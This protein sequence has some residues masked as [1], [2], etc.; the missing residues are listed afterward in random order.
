MAPVLSLRPR[1]RR[2]QVEGSRARRGPPRESKEKA[3]ASRPQRQRRCSARRDPS[4][5]RREPCPRKELRPSNR[6]PVV[7]A[8]SALV[9]VRGEAT[10]RSVLVRQRAAVTARV[11]PASPARVSPVTSRRRA[12]L[13]TRRWARAEAEGRRGPHRPRHQSSVRRQAPA[14]AGAT[15]Q[16]VRRPSLPSPVPP[17]RPWSWLANVTAPQGSRSNRALVIPVPPTRATKAMAVMAVMATAAAAMPASC[18]AAPLAPPP[19]DS[20]SRRGSMLA[21]ARRRRSAGPTTSC[22]PASPP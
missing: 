3:S 17:S 5:S 18:R 12:R 10:R 16:S 6:S 21:A 4:V 13:P 8:A 14:R 11:P 9:W 2:R 20:A 7:Q 15:R 1:C 22:R 19:A